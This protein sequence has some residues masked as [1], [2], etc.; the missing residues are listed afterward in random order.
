VDINIFR[1]GNFQL[2]PLTIFI[3]ATYIEIGFDISEWQIFPIERLHEYFVFRRRK[4][5]F[6]KYS[7]QFSDQIPCYSFIAWS[8][9]T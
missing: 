7:F 8:A 1:R 5:T 4:S 6:K 3:A 2:S 9:A